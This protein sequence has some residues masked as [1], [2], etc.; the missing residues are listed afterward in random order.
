MF[1]RTDTVTD[2]EFFYNLVI[3]LLEDEGEHA[4]VADLMKWWNRLG[5][6][7][8]CFRT[9]LLTSASPLHSQVFPTHVNHARTVHED[10][11]IAKIKERRRLI[12][13]GQWNESAGTPTVP[14]GNPAT[15]MGS[16]N[17]SLAS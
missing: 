4:E 17:S 3:D 5:S 1:S 8:K 12:N 16:R 11:V 7:R 14:S 9:R 13:S 2:S 6:L 10:S 15:Q